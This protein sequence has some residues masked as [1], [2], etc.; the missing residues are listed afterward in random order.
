[1]QCPA[2]LKSPQLLPFSLGR[3]VFLY[4]T[5][6][7]LMAVALGWRCGLSLGGDGMENIFCR[8]L[9]SL[10][11]GRTQISNS[12]LTVRESFRFA[13]CIIHAVKYSPT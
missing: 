11:P 8:Q 1:M 4:S 7:V 9:W 12:L 10:Q 13:A 5:L 6:S 2:C 3:G